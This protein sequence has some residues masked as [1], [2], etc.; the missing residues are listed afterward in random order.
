MATCAVNLP[1]APYGGPQLI[2]SHKSKNIRL[3]TYGAKDPHP[4]PAIR[5]SFCTAAYD[6]RFAPS[7]FRAFSL[8]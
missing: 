5:E 8:S 3:R 4:R 2:R 1:L 7:E 6:G